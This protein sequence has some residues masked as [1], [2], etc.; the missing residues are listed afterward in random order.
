MTGSNLNISI[1]SI[2]ILGV[3]LSLWAQPSK[4]LTNVIPQ[5]AKVKPG[6]GNFLIS[7][8]IPVLINGRDTDI[9]QSALLFT[10][11]LKLSGGPVLTTREMTA[12][13]KQIPSIILA[14][15]KEGKLPA[16]GYKLKVTKKNI[17]ITG[18]SGAGLFY[19]VQTLFQLFPP[20][21]E[22]IGTLKALSRLEIPCIE[23]AD[24]PRY[25][26]RGMH[27]DVSRHF[28]PKEF[29]KKYIDLIAMYKMNTFQWH[30]TDDNGWRIE[31]KKYPKLTEIGAWHVEREE[32]PWNER[33]PQKPGEKATYGGFYTQDD[34]HEIVQYAKDKYVTIIPEIEMPAHSVE[35]LAAYPQFS[36]T[37]GPFTVPPGS[38]WPNQ[39][40]LCA[41]N[42]STFQFLQDV[43]SE[44][45]EL[46][47]ST[48]IHIGGDE[49]D[50]TRWKECPKCQARIKSEGLKDEKELQSYFIKRIEKFLI[51]KNRKMIGWD[52]ILEG[53]LAPEATVMSWRGIE[54]GIAAARKGHD[55][56]MTPTSFCYF[57]YYQADPASEPKAIG[58]FLTLKKVYSY[59]PTP[60]ELTKEEA[61]FILGTQGNVWTEYIATS[62]Q[63]EY[64][65]V[66]RMIALAEVA[67]TSNELKNWK[68][69]RQRLSDHFKRLDYLNV[70]YC[71]GS[72]KVDISTWFDK[73]NNVLKAYL[74]S[75]Q[76]DIPI[77]YTLNGNDPTPKSPVYN[78]P[79]EI[80]GNSYI[81][82]GLFIDEKV[83]EKF[84]ERS[85]LFH[86]ATGKKVMY[87]QPYSYRYTAGGDGA[88][89]DGLR[90]TINYRD[91]GWQGYLG[92]DMEVIIDLGKV[93]SIMSVSTTFLQVSA[94]WIFMPDSV[95]FSLSSD[96]KRFHSINE[97]GND[98]PKKTD[99][100]II[101]Q[102]S[103]GFPKTKARYVKVRAKNTGVCPPWHEGAGEPCWLFVDEIVVY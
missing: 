7:D 26:Y 87:F 19:G 6:Q 4:P 57:D 68:S 73:K 23:I 1:L 33:P 102:F 66:P 103:Q 72:Y 52:E 67:W 16:E 82:A 70:N 45:I 11:R 92:N 34:I 24:Q 50:K 37:G 14:V 64:M 32:L 59:E 84:S 90:G 97:L 13:D 61:R 31:I 8:Q 71:K 55:V 76:P 41:G 35:V 95:I 46:F 9:K 43:L 2:L 77:H 99:R 96:G 27:L 5:P 53:G 36:C 69:F 38:Y 78:D 89:T 94:S 91:G 22:G 75:E 48:Y 40:I 49:A 86:K 62:Q 65:A 88:L 15:A 18:G 20:E 39:D 100:P 51:S 74:E 3:S 10:E 58:G 85:I 56:I 12:A 81:K 93:D 28:F 80:R 29:I 79:I 60:G 30:L 101:K 63:A 54:G 42:D 21:I 98:V 44:V 25:P 83:Q 17:T 47:P